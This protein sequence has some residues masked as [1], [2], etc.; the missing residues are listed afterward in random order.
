MLLS[1]R[2]LRGYGQ[3]LPNIGWRQAKR[4]AASFVL[5]FEEGA[6][7]SVTDGDDINEAVYEVIDRQSGAD[8]CIGFA[9]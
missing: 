5:N 2:D 3:P 8:A 4:V 1:T 7:F 6:E 9:L